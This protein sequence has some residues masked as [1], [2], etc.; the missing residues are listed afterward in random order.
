[1]PEEILL[2][3]VFQK[4][5]IQEDDQ[6]AGIFGYRF[7][8]KLKDLARSV[9]E[10]RVV[11]NGEIDVT[12]ISLDSRTVRPGDIFVAVPGLKAD[13]AAFASEAVARGAVAVALEGG[14]NLDGGITRLIVPNA[15]LGIA[16]LATA[17]YGHPSQALKL[18]GVTGT[19]GKTT[20]SFFVEAILRR[21]GYKTGM[22]GTVGNYIDGQWHPSELTT[23]EASEIQRLLGQMRDER[24][25][26]VVMEASSHSLELGR[27]RGCDFD[28]GVFTNLTHDHLDFHRNMERYFDAKLKLFSGLGRGEKK[29]VAAVINADDPFGKKIRDR[30]DCRT[31]T[32]GLSEGTDLRAFRIDMNSKRMTFDLQSAEGLYRAATGLIGVHNVYNILA[33]LQTGRALG[34]GYE[35]MM[36]A[37]EGLRTVPGRMETIEA[38][39]GFRVTVDFA[40]SPDSLTQLLRTMRSLVAGKLIVVFGCTGDRDRAKR[41][42]MGEIARQYADF[43]FITTDDPYSEPPEAIIDEI[44]KGVKMA[45]GILGENYSRVAD[46][47]EAI[48]KALHRAGRGDW[49]IV[50]GRGHEKFQAV[51]GRR[52]PLDDRDVVRAIVAGLNPAN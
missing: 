32:Y 15:R 36:A 43:T 52:I 12:G 19:N 33:A 21:A 26:H 16:D 38:P 11:G 42:I 50:A 39:S 14:N 48:E 35:R 31:L 30:I 6:N 1:M 51:N 5:K 4:R 28:V 3:K 45:G 47:R 25:S 17:F 2:Q 37:V 13:G 22:I 24:V 44:E 46:R 8:M 34:L 7:Q 18:V 27:T 41:P 23:P 10:S 29:E 20:T 40:H 49:V 9:A